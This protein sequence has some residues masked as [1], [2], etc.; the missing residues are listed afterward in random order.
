MRVFIAGATGAIGKSLVPQLVANGHDVTGTTTSEAKLDQLRAAGAE[1]V[2][3]DVLDRQAAVEAVKAAQPEVVVH[4]ATGLADIG[5][6]RKMAKEFGPT[7]RLRTEGTDHLLE[8]AQAVGA[9]MVA[10]SFAGWPFAREG[11]PVKDEDAPLDPDPPSGMVEILAAIKHLEQVVT[12]AG[13]IVLRY[14]G[15][16]GPGTGFDEGGPQ[17]EAVRKRQFPIVGDGGGVW[18]LIQIEDAA[19]ATVAAIERGAPGL[20]N[21]V[22]DEPAPV[23]DFLPVLADAVGAKPPRRLPVWLARLFA[24][25]PMVVML[26]DIRGASN[27]KA[28][29]E[30]GWTPAHPTWREGFKRLGAQASPG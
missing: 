16:Y 20:Y 19:S 11:G 7:N 23:R 22:D 28:K 5:N 24:G 10:Q 21:I 29:R 2:V 26:T 30:L 9:R 13:G 17:L 18:S 1:A 25:E 12:D 3:V 6:P 27:E 15:F 14:G 4:E 8:A